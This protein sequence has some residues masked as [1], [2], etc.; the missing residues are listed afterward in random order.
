MYPDPGFHADFN[1]DMFGV[2]LVIDLDAECV[3]LWIG[4][5]AFLWCWR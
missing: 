3:A 2:G 4:W 5:F 1:P